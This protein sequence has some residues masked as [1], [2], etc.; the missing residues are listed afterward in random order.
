MEEQ[1]KRRVVEVK[2]STDAP[3]QNGKNDKISVRTIDDHR[4]LF[5]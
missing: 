5:E 1:N 4:I 3:K 2:K